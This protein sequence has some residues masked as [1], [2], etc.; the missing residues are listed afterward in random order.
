[1]SAKS[2][3]TER[4]VQDS[5]AT[6]GRRIDGIGCGTG[7][8]GMLASECMLLQAWCQNKEKYCIQAL[9]L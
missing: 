2:M 3:C 5:T 4:I 6:V 7:V 9:S 1:M 8:M